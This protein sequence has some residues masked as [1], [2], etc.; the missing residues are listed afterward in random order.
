M[1]AASSL[2]GAAAGCTRTSVLC[3]AGAPARSLPGARLWFGAPGLRGRALLLLMASRLADSP[4]LWWLPPFK[5]YVK[6]GPKTEVLFRSTVAK[7][8]QKAVS[9]L[10][11]F[12]FKAGINT[13][14]SHSMG[15]VG[16]KLGEIFLPQFS[17][18]WDQWSVPSFPATAS[19]FFLHHFPTEPPFPSQI[20]WLA[21]CFPVSVMF[22]F[23]LFYLERALQ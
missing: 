18:R 4:V 11:L 12:I 9:I 14:W 8:G 7:A 21:F 2:R 23:I 16:L 1:G 10:Y 20:I 22:H 5:F 3:A 17:K 6:A 15:Y 19:L 13:T